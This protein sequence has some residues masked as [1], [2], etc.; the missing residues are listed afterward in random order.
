MNIYWLFLANDMQ[1]PPLS[2]APFKRGQ[3]EVFISKI[4][5]MFGKK[6]KNPNSY[7]KI[8]Q[9][10]GLSEFSTKNVAAIRF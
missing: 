8:V 5:A 7:K 6:K 10:L 4:C 2:L 9:F 1:T 3:I